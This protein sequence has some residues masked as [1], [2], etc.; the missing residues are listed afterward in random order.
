MIRMICINNSPKK[1]SSNIDLELLEEGKDYEG[2]IV[3][4]SDIFGNDDK[5]FLIPNLSFGC[6]CLTRFIPCSD[7]D[8][9]QLVNEKELINS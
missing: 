4:S 6:Y 9:T 2:E 8:E 7:I 5:G 3:D 1:D